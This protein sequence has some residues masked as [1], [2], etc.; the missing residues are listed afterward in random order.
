MK[1]NKNIFNFKFIYKY[2]FIIYFNK[3]FN[4]FLIIF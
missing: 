4:N 1:L 2:Y 3:I